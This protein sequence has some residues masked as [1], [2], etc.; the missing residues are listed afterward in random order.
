MRKQDTSPFP[1]SFFVSLEIS[2]LGTEGARYLVMAY[3]A[4][5]EPISHL[6][7]TPEQRRWVA[8]LIA[9]VHDELTA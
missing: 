8:D 9:Q 2:R 3:A 1:R 4:G 5:A 7:M 6:A